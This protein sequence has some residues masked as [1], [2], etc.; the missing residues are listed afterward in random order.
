[1]LRGM[2]WRMTLPSSSWASISIRFAVTAITV[3][4]HGE[5]VATPGRLLP[6]EHGGHRA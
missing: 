1:M 3:E 5:D 2:T 6:P 4:E